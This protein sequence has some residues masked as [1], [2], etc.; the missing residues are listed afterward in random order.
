M[1]DAGVVGLVMEE[2]HM[3]R[4]NQAAFP[5]RAIVELARVPG[6]VERPRAMV[7]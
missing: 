3:H 7:R 5:R 4:K 1:R 6:R 2:R